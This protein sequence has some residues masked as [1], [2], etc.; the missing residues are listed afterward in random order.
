MDPSE[1]V[2]NPKPPIDLDGDIMMAEGEEGDYFDK[3]QW[4]GD[5]TEVELGGR[6]VVGAGECMD[7][8]ASPTTFR[9]ENAPEARSFGSP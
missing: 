2:L 5:L 4:D 3:D 7:Q 8:A 6:G 9:P 1:L